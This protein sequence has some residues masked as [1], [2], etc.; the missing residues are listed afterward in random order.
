MV[1][2]HTEPFFQT[3]YGTGYIVRRIQI[4]LSIKYPRRGIGGKLI[5]DNGI[6]RLH[7]ARHEA[8]KCHS[9]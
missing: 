7:P 9:Q 2:C 5:A 4:Y 6:L 8:K 1:I 3:F